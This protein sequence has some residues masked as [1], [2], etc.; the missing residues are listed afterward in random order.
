MDE[1]DRAMVPAGVEGEMSGQLVEPVGVWAAEIAGRQASLRGEPVEHRPFR[2]AS[3][4]GKAWMTGHAA[5]TEE[6]HQAF[7][8]RSV[9]REGRVVFVPREPAPGR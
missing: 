6:K 2:S 5:G 4:M 9:L 8:C 7:P 1:A 3:E